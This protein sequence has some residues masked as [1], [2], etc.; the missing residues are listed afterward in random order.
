MSSRCVPSDV[1][2]PTARSWRRDRLIRELALMLLLKLAL[3]F[4]LWAAFF[5]PDRRVPV[6]D[7]RVS[8]V[9]LGDGRPVQK[10]SE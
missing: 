10:E 7:S 6:S 4:A 9:L 5:A 2:R 1:S 8:E 3:L